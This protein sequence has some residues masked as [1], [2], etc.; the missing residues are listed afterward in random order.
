VTVV[1]TPSGGAKSVRLELARGWETALGDEELLREV[2]SNRE[3]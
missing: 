1:C 3:T 2:E